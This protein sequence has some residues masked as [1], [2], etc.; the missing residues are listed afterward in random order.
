MHILCGPKSLVKNRINISILVF[1][2]VLMIHLLV[3][4][5]YLIFLYN[6]IY[7]NDSGEY[8]YGVMFSKVS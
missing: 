2:I 1:T 7:D 3:L 6:Y 8:V 5:V 4:C